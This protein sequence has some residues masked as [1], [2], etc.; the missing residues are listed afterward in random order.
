MALINPMSPPDSPDA[1]LKFIAPLNNVC[2][3]VGDPVEMGCQVG[4]LQ[5]FD[6]KWV[7]PLGDLLDPRFEMAQ[8]RDGTLLLNFS[9]S[10]LDDAGEYACVASCGN[11]SVSCSCVLRVLPD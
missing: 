3:R 6:V 7:G 10:R 1:P 9:T 11:Y 2:V 4:G 5:H 8:K